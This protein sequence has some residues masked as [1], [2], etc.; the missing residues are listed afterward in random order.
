MKGLWP[1]KHRQEMGYFFFLR[2]GRS[3][4][5]SRGGARGGGGNREEEGGGEKG[6]MLRKGVSG[7]I[8][9]EIVM[10]MG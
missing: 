2:K 8:A 10:S 9:G 4:V 1:L 5:Q 6:E 3:A 7:E